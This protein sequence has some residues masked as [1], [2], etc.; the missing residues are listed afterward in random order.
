MKPNLTPYT[1]K[2]HKRSIKVGSF[3][4]LR[5]LCAEFEATLI[6]LAAQGNQ[7]AKEAL[8]R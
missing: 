6:E 5:D 2:A 8:N 3:V 4:P 7:L 1:R